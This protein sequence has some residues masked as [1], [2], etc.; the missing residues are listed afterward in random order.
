MGNLPIIFLK[1]PIFLLLRAFRKQEL[2]GRL[3]R[4]RHFSAGNIFSLR[5]DFGLERP[6]A[7]WVCSFSPVREPWGTPLNLLQNAASRSLAADAS[8]PV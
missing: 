3:E 1:S 6:Q 8:G 4:S 2:A 5:N 7:L